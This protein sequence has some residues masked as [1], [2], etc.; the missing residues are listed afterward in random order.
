MRF[1]PCPDQTERAPRRT[2]SA[3]ARTYAA[4]PQAYPDLPNLPDFMT[5]HIDPF[6]GDDDTFERALERFA[7]AYADQNDAD[8]AAF[9][10]AAEEHRVEVERGV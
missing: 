2:T 10:R 8:Y 4:P 5:H 9:T 1:H 7:E 6:T 3:L